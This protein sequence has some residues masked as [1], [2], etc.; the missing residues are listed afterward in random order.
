MSEGPRAALGAEMQRLIEQQLAR[1]DASV[2]SAA[3]RSNWLGPKA[4]ALIDPAC[5]Q[6]L[7]SMLKAELA[8]LCLGLSAALDGATAMSD[9]GQPVFLT[10][11]SGRRVQPLH[12]E[13]TAFFEDGLFRT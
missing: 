11:R 1:F 6:S 5:R 3:A 10:D 2:S 13:L 7:R 4:S 12:G 8:H 9:G